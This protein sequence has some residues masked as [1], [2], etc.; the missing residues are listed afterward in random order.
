MVFAKLMDCF[1]KLKDL[2]LKSRIFVKINFSAH[3]G[4]QGGRKTLKK[5]AC[6]TITSI[7]Y[8]STTCLPIGQIPLSNQVIVD[9]T[10][11]F[12]GR[13][14]NHQPVVGLG[15]GEIVVVPTETTGIQFDANVHSTSVVGATILKDQYQVLPLNKILFALLYRNG[16]GQCQSQ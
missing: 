2:L 4:T 9:L 16:R 3:L 1:A 14:Q 6:I 13:R 11:V 12:V 5:Q 10:W 15:D 8:V 7:N